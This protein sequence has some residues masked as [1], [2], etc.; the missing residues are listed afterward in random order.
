MG[1]SLVGYRRRRACS[2]HAVLGRVLWDWLSILLHPGASLRHRV[3]LLRHSVGILRQSAGILRHHV[4]S[5]RQSVRM[6]P[7]MSGA[8]IYLRCSRTE[9]LF[10][11]RNPEILPILI[12]LFQKSGQDYQDSQDFRINLPPC[13]AP[14][15]HP[16][17]N[18]AHSMKRAHVGSAH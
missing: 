3:S 17:F 4:G 10:A 12:I 8:V 7:P 14:D 15:R 11:A 18:E 1:D 16:T 6:L 2:T 13:H 9:R 5:F